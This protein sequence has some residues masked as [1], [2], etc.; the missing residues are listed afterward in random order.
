MSG[1]W[2]ERLKEIRK[3]VLPVE[4]YTAPK[5]QRSSIKYFAGYS[6]STLSPFG[7]TIGGMSNRFGFYG[8][9]KMNAS[10]QNFEGDFSGEKGPA[11]SDVLLRFENEKANSYAVTGGMV[12][13]STKWL[14]ASVGVGYW[15]RDKVY[16]FSVVNDDGV[17]QNARYYRRVDA[18]YQ[19]ITAE[20]D[21][22]IKINHLYISVG[23]NTLNFQYIDLNAGI[24]VFF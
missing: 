16:Q 13:R 9:F 14:S 4:P 3:S 18:S 23:I 8:R 19:G 1:Y 22:I 12:V 17:K 6:F 7:V 21:G 10:F 5:S 20:A 2:S 24:G 11:V 15:K